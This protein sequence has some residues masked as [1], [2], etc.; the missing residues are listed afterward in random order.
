VGDT[1][2]DRFDKLNTINNPNKNKYPTNETINKEVTALGYNQYCPPG[3]RF[4]NHT[5][6]VLMSLYLPN[7]YFDRDKNGASFGNV[8]MP[9]R[10]YYDR[11]LFEKNESRG[12]TPADITREQN[13]VGW[14]YS[15]SD[16]KP[17]CANRTQQMQRSRCVRDTE[18]TG[19]IDGDIM[20]GS[21]KA[22]PGD[23]QQV[24]FSFFSSGASFVS[25]ALKL[26]YTDGS[27]IYHEVDIPIQKAPSGLQFQ[28]S[29][30]VTLPSLAELSLDES[31]AEGANWKFKIT[32]RNAATSR[33]FEKSFPITASHL[34]R[35]GISLPSLSNPDKGMPVRVN[36]GLRNNYAT[37]SNVTLHW[38]APE[39]SW[40]TVELEDGSHNLVSFA[41]DVYLRDIIGD[42]AWATEANR[43]KEYQFYATATCSDGTHYVSETVANELLRLNYCANPV[44]AGGWTSISQCSGTWYNDI[45][46][47]SFASGDFIEVDMDLTNCRYKYLTGNA[48][49]DLGQDDLVGFSYGGNV[50]DITKSLIWYYPSVQ[51]LV[52]NDDPSTWGWIRS[53]IH[54]GRWSAYTP[55]EGVLD[56]MNLILDKDGILRDGSRFTANPGDWNSRVKNGLVTASAIQIGS[57][58]G[59]HHSRAIYNFVRVVRTKSPAVTPVPRD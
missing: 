21:D 3:Y 43:Y 15:T 38:K 40:Q 50:A 1:A 53:R 13:K 18:M 48:N 22:C 34:S 49:T 37:I 36:I 23:P 16:H 46:N 54:A 12:M 8:Y 41:E 33:T 28:A 9:T 27:D 44:P 2:E 42:G 7:A 39:G 10:T 59:S 47:L 29:Q 5:E 14:G 25:A 26:C 52:N 51:N 11:G 19:W 30:T 32:L 56:S 17:H 4:P 20:M 35:C 55:D 58:E 57:T 31:S 45:T 24:S 6:M